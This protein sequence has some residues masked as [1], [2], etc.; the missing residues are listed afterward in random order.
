MSTVERKYGNLLS[1]LIDNFKLSIN[2]RKLLQ[3]LSVNDEEEGG[4][5]ET[6]EEWVRP[7]DWLEMPTV[8]S[9]DQTFVGLHAIFDVADNFV[10]M[11]FNT[12][13]GQ[14]QV[15]WGDGSTPTLHNS[16]V[17][18]EYNYNYATYDVG[19]TTLSSRGYKQAIITVTPVS[20]NLTVCDLFQRYTGQNQAYSTGFLDCILSLPNATTSGVIISGNTTTVIRHRNM[21]RFD[22]KNYGSCNTCLNLFHTCTSLQ[23]VPLFNTAS[24]ITMNGMF[25][26]CSSLRSVPLFNTASVTSMSSMFS[27]CSSLQSVPLFNT[28]SVTVM[29]SMFNTCIS[30]QSVPLFNTASVTNMGSMFSGCSS[31]RSV[32]AFSTA[33]ITTSSGTD[34]ATFGGSCPSLRKCSVSFARAISFLSSGLGVDALVE[35]FTNLADRTS[36]TSAIITITNNYGAALLS[37]GQRA[38]ATGKNWSITG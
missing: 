23:S 8:L 35:I 11:L 28:A 36:T 24:V 1:D 31:L 15:D 22:I 20:G 19:N 25:Q 30:L 7:S 32:P 9:T 10:S 38:I 37:A 13:S 2:S 16:G 33:S 29:N 26:S 14:Y 6:V 5:E 27:G 18:A 4:E 12:S 34:F 3:N 17:K 21:E